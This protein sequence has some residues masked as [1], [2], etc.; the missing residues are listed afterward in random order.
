MSIPGRAE[1]VA[2]LLSLDPPAWHL[3]HS[4]AVAEVAAWLAARAADRGLTVD[5]ALVESAALLHDTD[6]ALPRDDPLRALPHG[7]GSAR[8]LAAHGFAELAPVVVGHPVSRLADEAW[9]RRWNAEAS[10]E[11][12]LVAYADKRAGQRLESMAARFASWRRRYPPSRGGGSAVAPTDGAR[13]VATPSR[14]DRPPSS[15][16]AAWS[17]ETVAEV[18]GRAEAI[19]RSV[20]R[21]LGIEP[22][23]VG[24]LRWTAR[25]MRP[26]GLPPDLAIAQGGTR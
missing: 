18:A 12:R 23:D 14:E 1:A 26:V 8:W 5:R 21:R 25:A 2:L 16:R 11:A 9:W 22:A 19:E 7:E 20:C 6:K 10:L 15:Q 3:R 4:R 17:E 13:P 24:R